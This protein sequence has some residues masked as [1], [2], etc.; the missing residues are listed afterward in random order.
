ML[1]PKSKLRKLIGNSPKNFKKNK[2]SP[3]SK[4]FIS[5]K[6]IGGAREKHYGK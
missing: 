2:K 6:N 5:V 4:S 1:N 3:D